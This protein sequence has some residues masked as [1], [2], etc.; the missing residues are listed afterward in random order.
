M[1]LQDS[2][3][4]GVG[5]IRVVFLRD[6]QKQGTIPQL[7]A[8]QRRDSHVEEDPKQGWHGDHLQD[9]LHQNR[10]TLKQRD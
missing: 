10:Q 4:G 1:L 8:V 3:S 2:Y 7:D 6:E 9:R 5:L